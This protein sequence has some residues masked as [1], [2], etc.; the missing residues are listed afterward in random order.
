MLVDSLA[1]EGCMVVGANSGYEAAGVLA[2]RHVDLLI[3]DIRMPGLDGFDFARQA[4]LM[5]PNLHVIYLSAY[6]TSAPTGVGTIFGPVVHKPIR[7]HDLLTL[8]DEAIGLHKNV[9]GMC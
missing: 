7:R 6:F 1:D 8:V 2:G 4:K 3:T 9:D 5:R